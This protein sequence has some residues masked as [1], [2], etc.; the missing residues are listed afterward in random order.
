MDLRSASASSKDLYLR[1]PTIA[2]TEGAS[3]RERAQTFLN[4][5]RNL[6]SPEFSHKAR[7]AESKSLNFSTG[8][9][10]VLQT[11]F[12]L[13]NLRIGLVVISDGIALHSVE[14][15]W[16][17]NVYGNTIPVENASLQIIE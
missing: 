15:E 5:S 6:G 2:M 11:E 10:L 1:T 3:A 8:T 7:R 17:G 4:R 16:G 13:Q 9:L 14:R 12:L